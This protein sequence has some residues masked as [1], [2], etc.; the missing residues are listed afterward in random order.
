MSLLDQRMTPCVRLTET[1][2][3]TSDG[4]GGARPAWTEG[5]RFPAALVADP[6]A[7]ETAADRDRP[8]THYTVLTPRAVALQFHDV[9]RRL[10]DGETF[11]VISE[12]N[13]TPPSASL[14][15]RSVK[16]ERWEVPQ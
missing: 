14:D 15:L 2:G 8:V 16:A 12:E 11:R 4:L 6:T 13:H 7:V 3:A 10:S 5:E 1:G 9:L